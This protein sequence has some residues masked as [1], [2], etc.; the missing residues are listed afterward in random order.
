MSNLRFPLFENRRSA[1]RWVIVSLVA[2]LSLGMDRTAA[3]TLSNATGL[4]VNVEASG[5]YTITSS[6]PAWTFGGSVGQPPANVSV[7]SGADGIGGF[8]EIAFTY[9]DSVS[10]GVGIRAY[11]NQPV[12]LFSHTNLTAGANN[13]AFPQLTTY[14]TTPWYFSYG[15][16]FGLRAFGTLY[17]DSPWI[18]FFTNYDSF[19]LSP[20]ANF[21]VASN[22]KNGDNSL[23]FGI[24]PIIT[25]L[26]A[27]FTHRTIL[28]LEHGI[29]RGFE[30]WG[31]AMTSLSGKTR[32]ANDASVELNKLGYWTDHGAAYYYNHDPT[33]GYTGTLLAVRDEF[34]NKGLPLGYMQLDSW[35][36]PKGT[37]F[38]AR[39]CTAD[40]LW[41]T[42]GLAPFQQQLGLPMVTHARWIDPDSPY[43]AQYAFSKDVSIDASFW[44][45]TL[46]YL[47]AANVVSYEQDWLAEKALT[48][49]NL[50]DP[51]AFMDLMAH[52][53]ASNGMS[54]QYCEPLARHYLQGSIYDNLLTMR[55]SSDRFDTNQWD[56]FLYDGRL[57]SALGSW[58]FTDVFMSG[59]ERNLL[60][61]TLSAGIVGVGDALGAV[62]TNNLLKSVR[63]DGVI[64]KPDVCLSL[65]DQTW[66]QEIQGKNLPLIASTFTD[67]E[68][69]KACY[70]FSFARRST[71]SAA[72]FTAGQLGIAGN[73]FVYDYFTQIGTLVSNGNAF[74]FNTTLPD[75]FTGGSYFIVAPIGPSG[76]G[77]LGDTNKYVSRGKKRISELSDSGSLRAKVL[78]APGETSVTLSGYAPFAPS[79]LAVNGTVHATT[80][81][82][83]KKVFA[84]TL[85]PDNTGTATVTLNLNPALRADPIAGH[86]Q[87]SWPAASMPG[88]VLE[89]RNSFSS[90]TWSAVSNSVVLLGDRN[91]V[92]VDVTNATTFFR[93][94]K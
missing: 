21:M 2:A 16:L 35:W 83:V 7:V 91:T 49:T 50:T 81:D 54:M 79:V 60:I 78:F 80:Y 74:N 64:V 88:F 51:F 63:R 72:S 31:K 86:L 75:N 44:T 5:A 89:S 18:F 29:N 77:L 56:W 69:F 55:V 19:I 67:H 52:H 3:T 90:P 92:T 76:I 65:T 43:R 26:P 84:T 47:K 57:A 20:A 71:N 17:F 1:F 12:I 23:S 87:L 25:N 24:Q 94:R 9:A 10:H 48:L 59:E 53:A 38:G 36:Y 34:V 93:L 46:G 32:P 66:L 14:P 82:S 30:T 58:P 39:V 28:V 68:G 22:V 41:F 70:V 62:N 45:N 37:S 15:S 11:D 73:I 85:A 6:S 40:P 8:S 27:G 42:N 4:T 33:K 61:A 13:L